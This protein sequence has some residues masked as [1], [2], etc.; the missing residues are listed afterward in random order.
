MNSTKAT[1]HQPGHIHIDRITVN[2]PIEHVSLGTKFYTFDESVGHV[3]AGAS[4]YTPKRRKNPLPD[5]IYIKSSVF[6]TNELAYR[7]LFNCC[8]PQILQKH[9]F[10]GHSDLL[11]Y[12]YAIFTRQLEK[13]GRSATPE[14]HGLWRTGSRISVSEVHLTGNFWIEPHLKA[15]FLDAID[16]A[17]KSGKHRDIE[18][19]ISLGWTGSRRSTHYIACIYDKHPLLLKQ[20]TKP[21][22]Y[23]GKLIELA[24]GSIRI[25]LRLYEGGLAYRGLKSATSWTDLDVDALFFELLAGFNVGNA[26]QPLLT[27]DEK[28][29]LSKTELVTYTMWLLKQNLSDFFSPST[30]SRHGRRIKKETGSDITGN[31]RPE[32]L[33]QLDVSEL[34][35]PANIVAVPDW[36]MESEHYWAPGQAL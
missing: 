34:L 30:I 6:G 2:G 33:P 10:F 15:M 5:D 9:N 31:R 17:N 12:T 27:A 3:V 13:H 7:L 23:R 20:W 22:V 19:C 1:Q 25:E 18:S 14:E 24:N 16:E 28:K 8:P 35:C 32:R 36:L 11:D 4:A 26:I 21:G 29:G